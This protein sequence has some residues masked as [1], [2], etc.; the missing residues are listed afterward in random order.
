MHASICRCWCWCV[1]SSAADDDAGEHISGDG[2]SGDGISGDGISGDGTGLGNW[3]W[4]EVDGG[5]DEKDE[6]YPTE[7]CHCPS[8]TYGRED[9]HRSWSEEERQQC[10]A[11]VT[12]GVREREARREPGVHERDAR[13]QRERTA[14]ATDDAI[15]QI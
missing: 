15:G 3:R 11:H 2:I 12:K 7:C 13:H 1:D 6:L 8:P 4:C 5:G 9:G 14:N 10:R